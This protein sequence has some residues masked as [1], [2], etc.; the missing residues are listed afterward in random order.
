MKILVTGGAGFIG[1]HLVDR[2]IEFGH[3]VVVLDDLSTGFKENANQNAEYVIMNLSDPQL[4]EIISDIKPDLINHHAGQ[5]NVRLS[6]EQP[7]MDI[8]TN[9]TNTVRLLRAAG[10]AKVKKFIFASSGGAAYGN[11]LLKPI[12]ETYYCRP[13]SPYGINKLAAELYVS[14]YGGF[15]GFQWT[16]LRYANVYGPRQN[17]L[18]ESGIIPILMDRISK[19]KRPIVYGDGEQVRDYVHVEDVVEANM[20]FMRL[21]AMPND[22]FNIG[23]GDGTSL[24]YILNLMMKSYHGSI[25]PIYEP[26]KEGDL[27]WN[28]LCNEKLKKHGWIP[29]IKLEEGIESL[30]MQKPFGK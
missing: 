18:S 8:E 6:V 7:C 4:E 25:S 13:I 21:D 28:V 10:I 30:I 12:P 27:G 2:Y 1:S 5:S 9:L 11:T 16:I 26:A 15:Y 24:N 17:A 3:E 20:L 29:K 23:T 19:G 22:I 14:M